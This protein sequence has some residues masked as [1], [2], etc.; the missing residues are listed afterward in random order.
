MQ[1]LCDDRTIVCAFGFDMEKLLKKR[2]DESEK[3]KIVQ[4]E[5]DKKQHKDLHMT[6]H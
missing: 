1:C 2:G 6:F 4:F 5:R 3:K